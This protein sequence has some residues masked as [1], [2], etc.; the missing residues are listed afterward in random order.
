MKQKKII[1]LVI[2]VLIFIFVA[3]C[4]IKAAFGDGNLFGGESHFYHFYT[5]DSNILAALSCLY[6][7]LHTAKSLADPNYEIPKS[8]IVFKLIGTGVVTI[9]FLTV[10][11]FLQGAYGANMM[12]NNYS[13]FFL[14]FLVPILAMLSYLLLEHKPQP[15][16][17]CIVFALIPT[18]LYGIIYYHNVITLGVWQ[19]FYH[20]TSLN[21]PMWLLIVVFGVFA[22]L[23]ALIEW[24]LN[25]LLSKAMENH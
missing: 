7:A 17:W 18:M 19:D 15:K 12:F 6:L 4:I 21:M 5:Y 14:H 2:N 1:S 9:T 13:N 20:F 3:Y 11:F 8:A 10:V 23:V 22:V 24:S 16:L 25:H